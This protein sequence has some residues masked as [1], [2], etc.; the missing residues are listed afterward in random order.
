MT[1]KPLT[2]K[3]EAFCQAIVKG[4]LSQADAYRQAYNAKAMKPAS[5][6]VAASRL[7]SNPMVTLRVSALRAPVVEQVQLTLSTHL[8]DLQ[9]IRDAALKEGK[10]SAA[11]M[12][13]IAR[14]KACGHYIIKVED[15]TDPLKKAMQNMTPAQAE[16]M[17]NTL[18]QAEAAMRGKP[19][20]AAKPA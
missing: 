3:Q 4:G 1:I 15:V 12:A 10:Y 11:A 13:E 5:V 8:A 14:G 19:K 2:A 9:L 18:D 6:Q 16:A 20:S 7:M 17:L